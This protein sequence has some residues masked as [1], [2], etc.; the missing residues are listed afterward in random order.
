MALPTQSSAAGKGKRDEFELIRRIRETRN[1]T[2]I[3]VLRA[4]LC[5]VIVAGHLTAYLFPATIAVRTN[6]LSTLLFAIACLASLGFLLYLRANPPYSPWR[7]Y[8]LI[9][10]D[11][12]FFLLSFYMSIGVLPELALYYFPLAVYALM[13]VLS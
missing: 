12:L 6:P 5:A 13:I 4:A 2:V 11:T 10:S 8:L 9:T 7:K 3:T 1:E